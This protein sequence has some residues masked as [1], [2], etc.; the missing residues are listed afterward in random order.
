MLT[1]IHHNFVFDDF[2]GS[3]A[4]TQ[5]MAKIGKQLVVKICVLHETP[6]QHVT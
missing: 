5:L 1:N 6:V 3:I 4:F 2:K